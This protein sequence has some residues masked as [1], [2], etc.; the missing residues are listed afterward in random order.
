M[1]SL[2]V[3]LILTHR[4]R[5][6]LYEIWYC[7]VLLNWVCWR[8]LLFHSLRASITFL[9][10]TR[11]R[12]LLAHPSRGTTTGSLPPWSAFLF[13]SRIL[14]KLISIKVVKWRLVR[15]LR[16]ASH[17]FVYRLF[18]AALLRGHRHQVRRLA[19][20][21]A[22]VQ[23]LL[24]RQLSSCFLRGSSF[25]LETVT[26]CAIDIWWFETTSHTRD[27]VRWMI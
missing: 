16:L 14:L 13:L 8:T 4:D 10:R 21:I 15:T 23:T 17:M 11:V 20:V 18:I 3:L 19:S 24:L 5:H 2:T 1:W 7:V 12:N 22:I 9:G 27:L 25:V 26:G 6:L